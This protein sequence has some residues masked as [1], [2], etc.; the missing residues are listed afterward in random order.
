MTGLLDWVRTTFAD[1]PVYFAGIGVW[2]VGFA[3]YLGCVFGR[4]YDRLERAAT[5]LCWLGFLLTAL[6]YLGITRIGLP[7]ALPTLAG[8]TARDAI[9]LVW[10]AGALLIVGSWLRL[11]NARTGWLGLCLGMAGVLASWAERADTQRLVLVGGV[12]VV[13]VIALASTKRGAL[14][15]RTTSPSD[16]ESELA[17]LCGSARKARRLIREELERSPTLTRSGAAMAVVTRL[18]VERDGLGSGL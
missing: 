12:A 2:A 6:P 3:M 11:V 10:I 16:Y 9:W 13:A 8:F 17:R 7:A 4:G 18:R 1:Q 15:R 14:W 5:L